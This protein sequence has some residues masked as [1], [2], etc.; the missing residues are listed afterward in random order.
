MNKDIERFN[1]YIKKDGDCWLWTGGL[2][3]KGY[4]IFFYKKRTCFAHRISLILFEKVKE[5]T[6]GLLVCH[7]CTHKNCVN[8][9]HLKEGTSKDNSND[10]RR[11]GTLLNGER[12]HFAKLSW[13]IVK[14]IRNDY[15]TITDKK[16]LATKYNVNKSTIYKIVNNKSW[17]K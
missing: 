13:D 6:P 7:S 11:D 17:V 1:K 10:K 16:E 4:G 2:D 12:C 9:E 5:L 3:I 8:P 15:L 14:S